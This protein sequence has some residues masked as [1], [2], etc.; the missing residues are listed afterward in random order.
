MVLK[1]TFSMVIDTPAKE[2][3]RPFELLPSKTPAK[4]IK[5]TLS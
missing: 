1:P 3:F 5:S 2:V 4:K